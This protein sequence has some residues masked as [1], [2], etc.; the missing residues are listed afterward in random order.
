MA[1]DSIIRADRLR[2]LLALEIARIV[3]DFE[4]R[5][6]FLKFVWSAHRDRR[7]FLDTVFSR[8]T[9]VGF[10]DLALLQTEEVA[11]VE[12]EAWRQREKARLRRDAAL[13]ERWVRDKA[14]M[15]R[16]R[17]LTEEE[18]R[19]EDAAAGRLLPEEQG[20]MKLAEL[21]KRKFMQ[22]YY[23]RGAFYMDEDEMGEG[24]VRNVSRLLR[25]TS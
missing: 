19:A 21:P 3:S 7:P 16:R 6:D 20:A 17:G 9:T 14:E 8:W 5:R 1:A 25:R 24:D 13:R 22:K 15:E 18:R 12:Y 10:P 2:Q 11:A 4:I 23:H